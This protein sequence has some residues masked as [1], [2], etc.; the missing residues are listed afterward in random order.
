MMRF[1]LPTV[2]VPSPFCA[3]SNTPSMTPFNFQITGMPYIYNPAGFA[4]SEPINYR[5]NNAFTVINDDTCYSS[6]STSPVSDHFSDEVEDQNRFDFSSEGNQTND[7]D[8]LIFD[9]PMTGFFPNRS[10]EVTSGFVSHLQQ[11]TVKAEPVEYNGQYPFALMNMMSNGPQQQD[12]KILMKKEPMESFSAEQ[13]VDFKHLI[14]NLLVENYNDP[15][16][17]FVRPCTVEVGA[18]TFREGFQFE[19]SENPDKKLPELYAKHIRKAELREE[20]QTSV[21]I[22]DLYKFYLRACVELLSKYFEKKDKYTFLYDDI[23]LFI[24]GGSLEEAEDR[25]SKM[26]TRQRKHKRAQS[27]SIS[28]KAEKPKHK[29][30]TSM[31]SADTFLAI[32]PDGALQKTTNGG[33]KRRAKN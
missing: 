31:D 13:V 27:I 28:E 6:G 19:E 15:A 11:S 22:Q 3:G 18:G 26:G 17:V 23:P 29:R 24:R 14:Y 25:I 20:N 33:K 7:I 16:C 21:F 9:D 12:K 1:D 10:M 30:N 32:R 4:F 2:A 8:C 5:D